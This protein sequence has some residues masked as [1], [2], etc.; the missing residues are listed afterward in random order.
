MSAISAANGA[1]ILQRFLEASGHPA[2]HRGQAKN[3][4]GGSPTQRSLRPRRRLSRQ[5]HIINTYA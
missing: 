1:D 5:R 4:Q 3:S 2:K